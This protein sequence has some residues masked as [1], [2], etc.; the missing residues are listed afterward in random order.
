VP[1]IAIREPVECVPDL[2]GLVA[3]EQVGRVA[4]ED[5]HRGV[6]RHLSRSVVM[7]REPDRRLDGR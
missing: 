7:I 5:L 4:D 1:L 3:G 2:V 6:V